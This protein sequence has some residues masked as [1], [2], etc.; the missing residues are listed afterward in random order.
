MTTRTGPRSV[1]GNLNRPQQQRPLGRASHWGAGHR[2]G[3]EALGRP[4]APPTRSQG[5][6]APCSGKH[7]VDPRPSPTPAETSPAPPRPEAKGVTL[8]SAQRLPAAC[9]SAPAHRHF[10]PPN[11]QTLVRPPGR[12]RLAWPRY[13]RGVYGTGQPRG[14]A[15]S[16]R[17]SWCV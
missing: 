16:G 4:T 11:C 8:A 1:G 7:G 3:R 15:G 12:A 2:A 14:L 5:R 10:S 13:P 6:D 17:L 9:P